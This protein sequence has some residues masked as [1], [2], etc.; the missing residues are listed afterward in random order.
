MV[1]CRWN[2]AESGQNI[3]FSC[4]K[5]CIFKIRWSAKLECVWSSRGWNRLPLHC[6]ANLFGC[7]SSLSSGVS[8]LGSVEAFFWLP[9]QQYCTNNPNM[10]EAGGNDIYFFLK[11]RKFSY[12]ISLFNSFR[13]YHNVAEGFPFKL[14][15][16]HPSLCWSLSKMFSNHLKEVKT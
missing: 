16:K 15:P 12:S 3:I 7:S 10:S 9:L 8:D 4:Y 13:Q 2:T 5:S 6:R 14:E 11:G 1:N